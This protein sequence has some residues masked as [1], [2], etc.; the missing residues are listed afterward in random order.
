MSDMEK[1]FFVGTPK[2]RKRGK[3]VHNPDT[4]GRLVDL[5]QANYP[6]QSVVDNYVLSHSHLSTEDI[7]YLLRVEKAQ[8]LLEAQKLY[9][10]LQLPPWKKLAPEL[11]Q[12]YRT[13]ACGL[14]PN[15]VALSCNLGPT[16]ASKA[17]ANPE[18]AALLIGRKVRA[19]LAKFGLPLHFAMT[20]EF[21]DE[22]SNNPELHFHG[23]CSVPSEL[24]KTIW[25]ELRNVL[26]HDY[27]ATG[28]KPVWTE[29]VRTAGGWE[30]YTLKH[31]QKTL[32]RIDKPFYATHE[33]SGLGESLYNEI[34]RWLK[35]EAKHFSADKLRELMPARTAPPADKLLARIGEHK[36][37]RKEQRKARS[38]MTR[39]IKKQAAADPV[40]FRQQLAR[41]L[42]GEDRK[43]PNR[44]SQ[45]VSPSYSRALT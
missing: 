28:N 30:A 2:G 45:D 32:I 1:H 24:K 8:R 26:A 23:A 40:L 33:A 19:V 11:K 36:A 27:V 22:R 5:Y 7:E 42:R 29:P 44:S 9:R 21:A 10:E 18:A 14:E 39:E 16:V 41:Q 43:E 31:L 25:N 6:S 3:A 20:L 38:R 35:T 34:R 13:A 4:A 15:G 12:A 37:R 17:L